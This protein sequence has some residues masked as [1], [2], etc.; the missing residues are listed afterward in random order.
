MRIPLSWLSEW[1]PLDGYTTDELADLFTGAGLEVEATDTLGDETIFTLNVTPNRG[2]CLSIFGVAQELAAII[3]GAAPAIP[4]QATAAPSTALAD[5]R[6]VV[7]APDACPLYTARR[8]RGVRIGASP[9]HVQAR[10]TAA[11][12]RPINNVVDAT[13]YVMLELGQPLHAFDARHIRGDTI[14]VGYARDGQRFTTLDGVDHALAATD[15]L[16]H[17][18][19]GAVALAGIM[20]GADSEVRADTTDVILESAWFAP[21][22]VRATS[23][24]LG[25]STES[26]R[27]FERHVDPQRV[28]AALARVAQLITEWS[29]GPAD[30]DWARIAAPQ[31]PQP[32]TIAFDPALAQRVLGIALTTGE[33]AQWISR[34]GCH[35]TPSGVL[36]T[37]TV[38]T[39]RA[40]LTRPIDLVEEIARLYGYQRI[41]AT[42]PQVAL[43][44][45]AEPASA[46][47]RQRIRQQLAA[48]GYSEAV[49]YAFES[50][51]VATRFAMPDCPPLALANPLGEVPTVLKTTLLSGLIECAAYNVRQGQTTI[52]LFELRPVQRS[53]TSAPLHVAGVHVGPWRSAAWNRPAEPATIFHLKDL[54]H[55]L[56]GPA[57][58]T[59]TIDTTHL[60][61]CVHP[62][63]SGWLRRGND[64]VGLFGELHPALVAHYDL[65]MAPLVF[66][67]NLD[68][69]LEQGAALPQYTGV[70]RHP[71]VQRDVAL[72]VSA[73]CS[74]QTISAAIWNA[75]QPWI[76]SVELF[77]LYAGDKIPA[78]QKSVAYAIT[79]R[80]MTRTL[81]DEEVNAAHR[82]VVDHV[83]SRLGATVR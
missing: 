29:G 65:P 7:D 12:M 75:Q 74:A 41:P 80:D 79:Y 31:L 18:A 52:R 13:N 67:W 42:T 8:I 34:T 44:V 72:L 50:T 22:G 70:I 56:M 47:I 1:H 63:R 35:V 59:V 43:A 16:I 20:G 25:L 46:L 2:D 4:A 51:D 24:R 68:A 81:T 57:Y 64:L 83:T 48:H 82:H 33:I 26:S 10:L 78:G 11:G 62:G 66:E 6:V 49:T 9:A 38:P 71:A 73:D 37:V 14:R 55:T 53:A 15:L 36:L 28:A 21:T 61:A 60:P 5:L 45:A 17:D 77:D 69:W 58:A 76:H 23:K 30:A 40:D 32:L 3:G 54:L 39:H 27:R 19:E